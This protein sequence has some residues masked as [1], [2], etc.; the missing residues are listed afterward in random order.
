ML[1]ETIILLIQWSLSFNKHSRYSEFWKLRAE[2]EIQFAF[3]RSC[4]YL[5]SFGGESLVG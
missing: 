5:T 1:L 4:T 2:Q 3:D